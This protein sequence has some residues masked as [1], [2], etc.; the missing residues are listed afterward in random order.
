MKCLDRVKK[1]N[2]TTES[3]QKINS[4]IE[5]ESTDRKPRKKRK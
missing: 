4:S 3:A 1:E 2:V 5:E